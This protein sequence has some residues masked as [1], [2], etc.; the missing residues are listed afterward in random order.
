MKEPID[1]DHFFRCVCWRLYSLDDLRR[2]RFK[3]TWYLTRRG[4]QRLRTAK[5]VL[6]EREG[7]TNV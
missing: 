4:R 1:T 7:M 5:T 2:L 3:L 6:A